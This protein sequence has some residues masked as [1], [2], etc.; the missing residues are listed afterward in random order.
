MET[1]L[2]LEDGVGGTLWEAGPLLGI[3]VCG[4]VTQAKVGLGQVV[5][6]FAWEKIVLVDPEFE[7]WCDESGI[8]S[9]QLLF[10]YSKDEFISF[11][12]LSFKD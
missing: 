2:H 12:G 1:F 10:K 9:V 6:T 8:N 5:E 4:G 11:L 3:K 7:F